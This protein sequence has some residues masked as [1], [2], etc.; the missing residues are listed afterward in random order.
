MNWLTTGITILQLIPAIIN[1]LKAIE[2]AVPGQ[3]LGEQ[4]IAAV[5]EILTAVSSQF[6]TL[7]PL[8]DKTVSVLVAFFNK[9][10]TFKKE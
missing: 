5:R 6:E 1:A 3:G 7:W 9:T 8:I 2:D 10:G 4:K